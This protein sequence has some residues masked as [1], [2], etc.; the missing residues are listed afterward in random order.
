MSKVIVVGAGA[1]GLLAAGRAV[2]LGAEVILFEKMHLPA[3]KLRITGKGRCNVGNTATMAEFCGHF[4]KRGG[5]F[6]RPAF[7]NFFTRHLLDHLTDLGVEHVVERGGRIFPASQK[8]QDVVDA[9]HD[10]VRREGVDLRLK[11]EVSG[12]LIEDERV[13]GVETAEGV[14]RGD[15]VILALGGASYSATGS[16]GD[17]YAL[18]QTAGH[19]IVPIRPALVPLCCA[20]EYPERLQ[21]L[22]L[23]NVDASIWCDGSKI[24]SAFGEMVFTHFGASGPVILTLSHIAVNLLAEGRSP[25]LSIDLKPALEHKQ[26]DDRLLRDLAYQ[27]RRKFGTMLR[28][29][30]PRKLIPVC[31]SATEIPID[32]PCH[33][34]TAEQRRRLRIWL[35][36]FRFVITGHRP[37]NEAIVTAGGVELSEVNPKTMESKLTRGLYFAGELL[38]INA[39]TGGYNVQAAF[40]TGWLAAQSAVG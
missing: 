13:V 27:N 33:Q 19:S 38:D 7:A 6:L 40:S 1:A 3:R 18:A 36:D 26:V 31:A 20:G 29:L 15:A 28:D 14:E 12:L 39:D 35:K 34:V 5:R 23:R 32:L 8:A 4:G 9:L 24:E 16:T 25:E 11:N 2:G 17:G 22:S 21:G 37:L 10:W 30:A